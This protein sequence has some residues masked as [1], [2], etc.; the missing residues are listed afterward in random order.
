[1]YIPLVI[2]VGAALL[3]LGGRRLRAG[4]LSVRVVVQSTSA[5]TLAPGL[6]YGWLWLRDIRGRAVGFLPTLVDSLSLGWGNSWLIFVPPRE[7]LA[8]VH[9]LHVLNQWLLMD[10][11]GPGLAALVSERAA[12][13]SARALAVGRQPTRRCHLRRQRSGG[14]PG[15]AP[16]LDNRRYQDTMTSAKTCSEAATIRRGARD[17]R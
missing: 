10:A 17:R 9:L 13:A 5:A 6:V 4:A 3:G 15:A 11:V 16:T 2:P 7:L 1:M 8:R 14:L 12:A